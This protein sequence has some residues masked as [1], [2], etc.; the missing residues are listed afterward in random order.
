MPTYSVSETTVHGRNEGKMLVTKDDRYLHIRRGLFLRKITIDMYEFLWKDYIEFRLA[1]LLHV[2]GKKLQL[3]DIYEYFKEAQK[4]EYGC[5]T[6]YFGLMTNKNTFLTKFVFNTERRKAGKLTQEE[7]NRIIKDGGTC[8]LL[9]SKSRIKSLNLRTL[10]FVDNNHAWHFGIIS[11]RHEQEDVLIA[12]T[13]DKREASR[14]LKAMKSLAADE[15]IKKVMVI[16][17]RNVYLNGEKLGAYNSLSF[18]NY[19][20][21]AIGKRYKHPTDLDILERFTISR[22]ELYQS[23]PDHIRTMEDI[24]REH[25]LSGKI[26]AS[27]IGPSFPWKKLFD[28]AIS[29]DRIL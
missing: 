23:N 5:P 24:L 28:I 10:R 9:G 29:K 22:S 19:R 17:N 18:N 1:V 27:H 15:Q 11:D 7:I 14:M 4:H 20:L 16:R 12:W 13:S 2:L 25:G 3:D 26:D 21:Q 6:D 8:I